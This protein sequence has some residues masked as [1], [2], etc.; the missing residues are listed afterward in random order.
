MKSVN[1][2]SSPKPVVRLIVAI[3]LRL[4][5]I[6]DIALAADYAPRPEAAIAERTAFLNVDPTLE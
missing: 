1:L 6:L 4:P 3:I 2:P 5:M